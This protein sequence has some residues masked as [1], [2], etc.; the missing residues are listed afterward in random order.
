[1]GCL[2]APVKL[3]GFLGLLAALALG[4]LY[5]DRL[6]DGVRGVLGNTGVVARPAVTSGRPGARALMTAR[7]KVDSLN[8]WRADSVILTAAEVASMIGVGLDPSVRSQLDSLEVQLQDGSIGV[9]AVLVALRPKER[10]QAAGPLRVVQP[11][12]AEWDVRSFRIRGFPI[13]RDAVPRLVSRA[14]GDTS[15]STVPIRIPAG[16][17]EIKVRPAGAV[18]YGVPRP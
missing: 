9:S 7:S 17:R 13:P 2:A 15:R 14:L 4:W 1:M 11:R 16:I 6:M 10:V 3:L 12:R 8:G 5:R 18:L